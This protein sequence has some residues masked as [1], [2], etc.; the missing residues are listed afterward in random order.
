MEQSDDPVVAAHRERVT[1]CDEVLLRAINDRLAAVRDLHT[2]KRERGYPAFDADREGWV[3]GW[4]AEVNPGPIANG[5]ALEIWSTVIPV[6]TREAA[7]LLE[8]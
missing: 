8:G 2:Y 3:R 5:A 4:I 1:A 7:R 6:L